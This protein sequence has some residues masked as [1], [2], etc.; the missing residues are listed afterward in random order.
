[1]LG[2]ETELT[3]PL[4]ENETSAQAMMPLV[5]GTL[6]S[7]ESVSFT[8]NTITGMIFIFLPND[9]ECPWVKEYLI[10][11]FSLLSHTLTYANKYNN[12][13]NTIIECFV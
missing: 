10:D 11:I 6:R 8:A 1:M 12:L 13:N 7:S 2:W 3:S 9:K 5:Y 4:D